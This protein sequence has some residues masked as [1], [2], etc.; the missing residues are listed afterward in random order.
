METFLDEIANGDKDSKIYLKEFYFGES[1]KGLH[2]KLSQE[3]DRDIARTICT[4]TDGD[5]T[6]YIKIGRYGIY[7]EVEG[8]RIT[9]DES[10]P[11]SEFDIDIIQKS[12]ENKAKENIEICINPNN[13]SPIYLKDGKFGVY[14]NCE[15]KN[16]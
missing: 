5:K 9:V 12:L 13:N 11:P 10:I 4:I 8:K 7:A 3:F 2:D 6:V 1:D 15:K 16:K 14:L